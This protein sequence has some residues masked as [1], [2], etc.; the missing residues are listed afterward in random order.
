VSEPDDEQPK[1]VSPVIARNVTRVRMRI[2]T[3]SLSATHRIF[4]FAFSPRRESPMHHS[5]EPNLLS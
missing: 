5:G 4:F 3:T 2:D 1:K